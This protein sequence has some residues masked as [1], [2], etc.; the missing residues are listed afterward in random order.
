M[1]VVVVD[2]LR[3]LV[4]D[5]VIIVLVVSVVLVV[6]VVV[7]VDVDRKIVE[8]EAEAEVDSVVDVPSFISVL[9]QI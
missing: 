4:V 2:M 9:R 3:E 5:E 8:S 7:R 1:V 6:V